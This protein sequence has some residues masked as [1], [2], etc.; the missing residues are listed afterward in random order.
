MAIPIYASGDFR[1][2]WNSALITGGMSSGLGEDTFLTITPNGPIAETSIGASG[3]ISYSKLADQGGTIE[4]IFKQNAPALKEI[5]AVAAALQL[6]GTASGV[7]FG[8]VFTL[9]DPTGA[10]PNFLAWNTF[11]VDKGTMTH[12]KVMGERTITFNCEKLINGD[13]Q[14]IEANIS[15]Y[16]K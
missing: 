2:T 3:D 10:I 1:I 15:S 7:P 8:G 11:L 13:P 5:D 14:S 16:L 4:L 6:V 12:Q 9:E